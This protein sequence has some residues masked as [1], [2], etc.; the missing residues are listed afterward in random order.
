[1][2][3]LIGVILFVILIFLIK[4]YMFASDSVSMTEI[5]YQQFNHSEDTFGETRI[6]NDKH[7]V[8][9]VAEILLKTN[10]ENTKYEKVSQQDYQVTIFYEDRS[11]EVIRI[12]IDFGRDFDLLESDRR[13]GAYILKDSESRETLR[14]IL[15]NK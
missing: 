6:I 5:E 12:W 10:H 11:T 13:S 7:T 4:D 2:K 3:K 9:K 15:T 14:K 1:M 8:E